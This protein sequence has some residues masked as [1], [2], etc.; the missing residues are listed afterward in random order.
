[1]SNEILKQLGLS[2]R[3]VEIYKLLLKIGESPIANL[4]KA[5]NIHSQLIYRAIDGLT[6][7]GLVTVT[8]RRY[9]KYVRAEDP[10]IL[11]KL[12]QEKITKLRDIIPDLLKL[13]RSSKDAIV[14]ILKGV[15]AL[16]KIRIQIIDNL[17][18]DDI[19]YILGGGADGKFIDLMGELHFQLEKRRVRREINKRMIA[20]ENQRKLIEKTN[21]YTEF[22]ETRYLQN[23][24]ST[25]S[26]I[27]IFAHTVVITL[28]SCEPILIVIES[29]D[30]VV[31]YTNYFKILWQQAKL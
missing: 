23:N 14:K 2:E 8:F 4:I 30:L 28:W 19:L 29:P 11:E 6:R 1:M 15:E 12:E 26:T 18:K 22:S 13:Q 20:Y 3:E 31:S 10:R 17:N 24:Y 16:R 9:K 5:A 25:P 27:F 21:P 7:K